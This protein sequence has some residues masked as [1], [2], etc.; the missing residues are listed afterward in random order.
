L[1]DGKDL[2]EESKELYKKQ[3]Q[4]LLNALQTNIV[5]TQQ[6]KAQSVEERGEVLS[7]LSSQEVKGQIVPNVYVTQKPIQTSLP[8]QE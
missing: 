8:K 5:E 6:V 7:P 4:D 2:H 3:A 1:Q